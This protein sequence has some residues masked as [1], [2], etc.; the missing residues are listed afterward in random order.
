MRIPKGYKNVQQIIDE[1][2]YVK[3]EKAIKELPKTQILK[4]RPDKQREI[5]KS[6]TTKADVASP[7]PNDLYDSHSTVYSPPPG[8]HSPKAFALADSQTLPELHSRHV[9]AQYAFPQK[10]VTS[11][12][13]RNQAITRQGFPIAK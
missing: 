8:I 6:M 9:E 3:P 13:R 10:T 5:R 11:E 2:A 12:K 4:I 1:N 7:A